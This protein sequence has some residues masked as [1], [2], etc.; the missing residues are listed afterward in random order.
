M[1][2]D[3]TA[4]GQII[5]ACDF[6]LE[7]KNVKTPENFYAEVGKIR[8]AADSAKYDPVELMEVKRQLI[9]L[10]NRLTA[11]QKKQYQDRRVAAEAGAVVFKSRLKSRVKAKQYR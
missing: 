7:L 1:A 5:T 8:M 11:E 4:C 3:T 9:A 6:L 2:N 10:T